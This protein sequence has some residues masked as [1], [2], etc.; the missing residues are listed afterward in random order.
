MHLKMSSAKEAA[1]LPS[2]NVLIDIVVFCLKFLSCFPGGPIHNKLIIDS[3]NGL[4]PSGNKPLTEP[5][6]DQHMCP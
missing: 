1:I 4:V 5:M 3:G 2:L 6:F